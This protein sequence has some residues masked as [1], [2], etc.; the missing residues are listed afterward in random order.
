MPKTKKKALP[1]P[2]VGGAT[3]GIAAGT[4]RRFEAVVVA[5]DSPRADRYIA[6]TLGI[7]TRSQIK[8]RGASIEVNGKTAKLS[9]LLKEGDQLAV[10]WTEEPSPSLVPEDIP[11]SVIYEDER[12]I[13]VDKAA[14]MV[15]HPGA[16]NRR[17][18][19]A[20]AVLGRLA[21]E[22]LGHPPLAEVPR[23]GIVHR[24][25]KDTTGVIIIAKDAEA[26][27]FLASQFKDRT[28]RKDYLAITVG[29]PRGQ[30][31]RIENQLGR[32]RR[33]RRRFT[34]VASGGRLAVTD[35]RLVASFGDYALIHLRPRTGRTHQL[36]VHLAGLGIPIVGDPI[37]GRRE[38]AAGA[39]PRGLMLH[40]WKLSIV[41]PGGVGP[42]LFKA[43]IPAAF[44]GFLSLLEA[45][46]GKKTPR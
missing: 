15:T 3:A 20:N 9:R 30:S 21:S 11:L 8:A 4:A 35:W 45:R 36:R 23:G 31:G 46:F 14:G 17:G 33:D 34:E 19:L 39:A 37:Y 24:L 10:S 38:A 22:S 5:L 16:G 29:I 6:E 28:T 26:L 43:P 13:V 44:V 41:L 42:S 40:A 27:A 7:L 2:V 1:Q 18:T 12:V 32:D 25:D